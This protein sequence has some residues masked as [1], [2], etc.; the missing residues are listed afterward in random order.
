MI[1]GRL[2]GLGMYAR[3]PI[4][5]FSGRALL[6]SVFIL[7]VAA[8]NPSVVVAQ[9]PKQAAQRSAIAGNWSGQFLGSAFT[10]EFRQVGPNWTGRYHSTKSG[11]WN[12]LN[13][14]KVT[15][16]N[17]RFEFSSQPRIV[18]SLKAS[19]AN[20]L[21]GAGQALSSGNAG[22]PPIPLTLTRS[23]GGK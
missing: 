16:G 14:V 3:N 10:F 5:V 22:P 2:K 1:S 19:G 17:V 18:V 15:G 12:N 7:A 9:A 8:A 4:V 6:P 21:T 13:N 23:A 20:M 11:K